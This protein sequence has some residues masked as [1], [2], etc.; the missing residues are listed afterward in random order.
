MDPIT[1]ATGGTRRARRRALS[2]L[3][4]LERGGPRQLPAPSRRS[5][6][7]WDVRCRSPCACVVFAAT[8]LACARRT[9]AERSARS[10]RGPRA[11][12]PPAD[13]G[14]QSAVAVALGGEAGARLLP[15]LA[16]AT[17]AD[18]LLRLIRR[19]RCPPP[20]RRAR[21]AWMIGRSSAGTPTAPCSWIWRA[22]ARWTCCRT[23][24][25]RPWPPGCAR[26]AVKSRWWRGID[27]ASARAA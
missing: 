17:S 9:F 18:T 24:G 11:A 5:A 6:A 25:P 15:R 7:A 3:R 2:G 13:G 23:A 1:F 27:P 19:L 10:A 4:R 26:A 22:V 12:H 14:A 21:W 16:M 20:R 8:T